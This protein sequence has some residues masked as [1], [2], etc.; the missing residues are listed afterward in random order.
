MDGP[1]CGGRG[2]DQGGRHAP[3]D[4]DPGGLYEKPMEQGPINWPETPLETEGG[5]GNPRSAPA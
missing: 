5:L 2:W 4:L 1:R 3:P